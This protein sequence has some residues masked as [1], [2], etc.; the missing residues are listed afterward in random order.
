VSDDVEDGGELEDDAWEDELEWRGHPPARSW[1]GWTAFV[2]SVAGFGVSFYLTVDHFTGAP[3]ICAAS[4]VIDCAKVT[5]SAESEVFGVLPVA[6]LG[7]VYFA[8]LAAI[9]LPPLWRRGGAWGRY[10]SWSR[11]V[12]AVAGI[13]MVFYLL[14]AELF[15][16]KA[17]CLW[18][19]GVHVVTF[20]FFV[21]VVATFPS[22][23]S[24]LGDEGG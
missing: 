6:L 23:A 14:Y 16:I 22:M 8:V 5:T 24:A 21:L 3:P 20:L 7:L 12:L 1:W 11:L 10:L 2:L 19:T 18:C 15:S 4:G 13:G 17:I 9:D